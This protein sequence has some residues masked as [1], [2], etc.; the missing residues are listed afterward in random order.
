[1]NEATI[2]DLVQAMDIQP[3]RTTT[4]CITLGRMNMLAR[5]G[6][7]IERA[8]RAIALGHRRPDD[9]YT[10]LFGSHTIE[11]E[12]WKKSSANDVRREAYEAVQDLMREA[13]E[14]ARDIINTPEDILNEA[15][16]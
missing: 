15:N 6:D 10:N 16:P 13:L 7:E 4:L 12:G 2:K 3:S 14:M 11:G 9:P 1:M 5:K 8:L